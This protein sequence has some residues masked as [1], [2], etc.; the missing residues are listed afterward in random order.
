MNSRKTFKIERVIWIYRLM[1]NSCQY[2]FYLLSFNMSCKMPDYVYA[3]ICMYTNIKYN[4]NEIYTYICMEL[5][6]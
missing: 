4:F 6:N 3:C 5:H 1:I 2:N